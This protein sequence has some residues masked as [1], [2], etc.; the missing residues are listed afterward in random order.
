MKEEDEESK[1]DYCRPIDLKIE[2]AERQNEINA[3]CSCPKVLIVD[4]NEANLFVLQNY[5]GCVGQTADEVR[6]TCT[7]FRREMARRRS[8]R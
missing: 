8:I 1:E 6:A 3:K 4:D 5:M 2:E 7:W